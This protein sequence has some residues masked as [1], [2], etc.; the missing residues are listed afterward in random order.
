MAACFCQKCGAPWESEALQ[1]AFKEYCL[2]C[3]AWLHSC[4]HCRFH[5]RTAPNQCEIPGTEAV[6]DREGL[7]FCEAFE[8]REGKPETLNLEKQQEARERLE[9]LFQDEG[10]APPKLSFDDLFSG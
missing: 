4:L 8:F 2:K 7:N 3:S 5:R 1:P 6:R 10:E 9:S